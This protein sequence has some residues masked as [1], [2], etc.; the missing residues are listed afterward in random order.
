MF[1]GN[2]TELFW[3]FVQDA[4]VASDIRG[5]PSYASLSHVA[6]KSSYIFIGECPLFHTE[7]PIQWSEH[8]QKVRIPP[9]NTHIYV[10]KNMD[11]VFYGMTDLMTCAEAAKDIRVCINKI[12]AYNEL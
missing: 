4:K 3:Q 5:L 6:S 8:V 2:I 12:E 11:D 1:L 9:Y 7:I 10:F